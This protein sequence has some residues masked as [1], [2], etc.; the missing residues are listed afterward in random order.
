MHPV[1][2][3]VYEFVAGN[4]ALLVSLLALI[5]S[6]LANS[7]AR[8]ANAL[9]AKSKADADHV[10][11]SEKRRELLNEI[12]RQHARMVTLM[13]LTAQQIALLNENPHMRERSADEYKRLRK[14]LAAVHGLGSR[15]E[16]QRQIIEGVKAATELTDPDALL[17]DTRRLTIHLEKDI[18]HEERRLGELS[19]KAGQ[20]PG[21]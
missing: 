13:L 11:F 16:E 3:L 12:D 19:V 5:I 17:A 14:N 2:S 21:A 4:A 8:H 10:R 20:P 9:N 7:T 15:Y 1:V 6:L 18:E